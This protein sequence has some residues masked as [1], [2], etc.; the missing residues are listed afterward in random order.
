MAGSLWLELGGTCGYWAIC[1][2]TFLNY[3]AHCG[4]LNLCPWMLE[5]TNGR[6]F[7]TF[8]HRKNGWCQYSMKVL[9][10]HW[11]RGSELPR[12]STLVGKILSRRSVK[13]LAFPL[14]R[15]LLSGIRD[16]GRP[17][18]YGGNDGLT[19]GCS[20]LF[21]VCLVVPERREVPCWTLLC[22][23]QGTPSF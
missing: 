17:F 15:L 4:L 9:W 16:W 6:M 12:W 5:R 14:A 10:V 13:Q 19:P 20:W 23:P 7:Y 21:P 11:S 3:I 18:C 8:K 2:V 22:N 1:L